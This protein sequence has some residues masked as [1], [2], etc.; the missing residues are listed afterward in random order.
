MMRLAA[1]TPRLARALDLRIEG[2]VLLMN[3]FADLARASLFARAI[4]G[5]IVI[6][7]SCVADMVE[8]VSFVAIIGL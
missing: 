2:R 4:R 1:S 3:A 8:I 7:S 5:G 6:L